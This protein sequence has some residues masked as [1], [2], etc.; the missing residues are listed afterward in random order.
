[1]RIALLG[2][3]ASVTHWLEDC[4]AAWRA[5]G[6]EVRV[7]VTRDPA[8]NAAIERLLLSDALGAPMAARMARGV[9][10]FS[11]DLIVVIGAYHQ[12]PVILER[13]A[14]LP[15]RPPII[16]WV[17]DVF[18]AQAARAAKALDAVAYTDS[19]LQS[20]HEDLGFST[21]C[22]FLPHAVD[23][24]AGA[25][26]S[27]GERRGMVFIGNP[28]DYRRQIVSSL[29]SPIS[30]Y[31]AGWA[32]TP[33]LGHGPAHKIVARRVAKDAIWQIY[34]SHLAA[35][36]IR[37][38]INVISGLN[39]RNFEPCIVGAAVVAEHQPDLERCFEPGREVLVYRDADELNALHDRVMADKGEIRA[40]CDAGR[41][42]VLADHTF[43]RRLQTMRAF[44]GA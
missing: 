33:T 5:D 22:I 40:I 13:I 14:A 27:P 6:H 4:A 19:G 35:L 1:L 11:P 26:V 21:P 31:G 41:A 24:R 44:L 20:L 10:T 3:V 29:R 43:R 30:L 8:V 23:P 37:N 36:N 15:H 17:G 2:K 7:E 25:A 42:R 28:T 12:P 38:E 34:G 32:A 39:Q 18:S 16:G 9:R